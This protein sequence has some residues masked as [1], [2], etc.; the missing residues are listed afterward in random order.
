MI[1]TPCRMSEFIDAHRLGA[2]VLVYCD[3]ERCGKLIDGVPSDW[4]HFQDAGELYK[5]PTYCP[6]CYEKRKKESEKC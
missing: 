3:G 5:D 6:A 2:V 4:M 1:V